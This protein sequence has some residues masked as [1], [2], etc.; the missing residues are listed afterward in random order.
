MQF[1]TVMEELVKKMGI[2]PLKPDEDGSFG[3][4]FDD[5]HELYF[6]PDREDRSILFHAEISDVSHL[7]EENYQNLLSASLLGAETSGCTFALNKALGKLVLWK[8][9]NE[10]F[11]DLPSLEHAI[12]VFLAQVISWK[13]KFERTTTEVKK[14]QQNEKE[15]LPYNY[16]RMRC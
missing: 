16:D 8:R 12:N 1:S 11:E 6:T 13:E 7:S 3:L 10:D 5:E 9:Y 14:T 4:L 15:P 2:G